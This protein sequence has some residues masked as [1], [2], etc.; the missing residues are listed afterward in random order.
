MT[1]ADF[2]DDWVVC[3]VIN[4]EHRMDQMTS[5][6]CNKERLAY[7]LEPGQFSFITKY[8]SVYLIATQYT[9]SDILNS[10]SIVLLET[11]PDE[12]CRK[13][14]NCCDKDNIEVKFMKMLNEEYKK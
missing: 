5:T 1:S 2:D 13:I 11:A 12:L 7:V 4:T 3:F 9:L 6:G 10:D 8:S 14:K